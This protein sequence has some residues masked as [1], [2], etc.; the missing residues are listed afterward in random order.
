[1]C[2]GDFRVARIAWCMISP[3]PFRIHWQFSPP[4]PITRDSE[5]VDINSNLIHDPALFTDFSLTVAGPSPT[6][7][8]TPTRTPTATNTRTRT[9]TPTSTRTSTPTPSR[10]SVSTPTE[11][12]TGSP[13][14]TVTI[15]HTATPCPMNFTDVQP[16]DY[17]YEA[18]RYLY[19]RGVISGYGSVFLPYNNTT[20]GQ[21]CKIVVLAEGF[22]VYAPPTPTF[23]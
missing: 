13:A 23:R 22:P 9:S 20:R 6:P 11:T 5:V 14:A 19:C 4:A 18:V 2:G 17:F 10:T 3:G 12:T 21:L 15:T 7:T 8:G 1:G 16:S